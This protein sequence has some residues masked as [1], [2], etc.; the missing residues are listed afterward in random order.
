MG[1]KPSELLCG[2]DTSTPSVCSYLDP[3]RRALYAHSRAVARVRQDNEF[4]TAWL[5][6]SEGHIMTAFSC[7]GELD[8]AKSAST[9]IIEFDAESFQC[10]N[11]IGCP[12]ITSLV[13]AATFVHANETLGYS[14]LQLNAS[15]A[16]SILAKYGYLQASA[17]DI[18]LKTGTHVYVPGQSPTSCKHIAFTDPFGHPAAI[19][20]S[21][22]PTTLLDARSR[23]APVLAKATNLVI[24]QHYCDGIACANAGI[25]IARIMADL[26]RVGRLPANARVSSAGVPAN[27]P[28]SVG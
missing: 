2:S 23:G 21:H 5:W 3:D 8:S 9:L 17:T 13:G 7:A 28:A 4:C 14:L 27:V 20:E 22:V 19:T 16:T 10:E 1:P 18:E 24:G 26:E 11:D 15:I 25:E 12:S 6:G